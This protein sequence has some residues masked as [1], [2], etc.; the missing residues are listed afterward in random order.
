MRSLPRRSRVPRK[1][2]EVS[3][4]HRIKLPSPA[5]RRRRSPVPLLQVARRD[6]L[7]PGKL[8]FA[9]DEWIE[10]GDERLRAQRV[11]MAPVGAFGSRY[12]VHVESGSS[13][14]TYAANSCIARSRPPGPRA[15]LMVY[16]RGVPGPTRS[17]GAPHRSPTQRRG[18]A[19]GEA[20]V[21]RSCAGVNP[22]TSCRRGR[23]CRSS[24]WCRSTRG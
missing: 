5:A 23:G 20:S 15:S 16:N 1:S 21:K 19:P 7:A 10:R 6:Q 4:G 14:R 24:S 8:D 9:V 18:T 22:P 2:S 17:P 3:S 12:V 13:L 11:A